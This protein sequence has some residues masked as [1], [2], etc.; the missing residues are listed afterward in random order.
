M[1]Y[2]DIV[3]NDI[4]DEKVGAPCEKSWWPTS[5]KYEESGLNIGVWTPR[6]EDWFQL[7]RSRILNG[8]DETLS[9]TKWRVPIRGE[10][11]TKRLLKGARKLAADFI[12][13]HLQAKQND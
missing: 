5:S 4:S 6:S 10:A 3:S 8:T 9:A 1:H 2:V 13:R 11:E 12:D 7:R